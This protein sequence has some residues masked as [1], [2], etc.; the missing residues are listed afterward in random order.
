M[1]MLFVGVDLAWGEGTVARLANETGLVCLDESGRV[2]DARWARGGNDALGCIEDMAGAAEAVLVAVDAP[3]VVRNRTSLRVCE[4]Q[5]GQ[6]YGR[7]KV[8]ANAT[9]LDSPRQAGVSL[10]RDL[11]AGGFAYSDGF[12]GPPMSGRHVF[13]CYPYTT[14]VG[15]A[16]LGYDTER[17]RYKRK[18][19]SLTSAQ[20][21]P[22]RAAA[23][24]E[25]VRRVAR[26][27]SVDPPL[28]IASHPTTAALASSPAPLDDLPYKHRED[29][30][31]AL[32]CAW[33]ASLWHRHGTDRCQVLGEQ[34]GSARAPT[35]I[36]PARPEQRPS[37]V[38]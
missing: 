28:L 23:C 16:E 12:A 18:P 10:L 21:R 30:L 19:K 8:S 27:E 2:L 11:E 1:R 22:S 29:L 34:D 15:A 6:R 38:A 37:A 32:I 35:I 17:P 14:I 31:D 5:V 3:L 7:W 13:E 25:L 36:A 26:L 33:T 24:D 9:N 4:R 20:W